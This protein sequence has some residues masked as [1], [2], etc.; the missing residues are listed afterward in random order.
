VSSPRSRRP[1]SL[2][3]TS[4]IHNSVADGLAG[5][6]VGD[7]VS[8]DDA[9]ARVA[10]ILVAAHDPVGGPTLVRFARDGDDMRLALLPVPDDLD[11]LDLLLCSTTPQEWEA[12]GL[13]FSGRLVD[14]PDSPGGTARRHPGRWVGAVLVLRDGRS[15]SVLDDGS[16]ARRISTGVDRSP[17]E[18]RFADAIRRSLGLATA[19]PSFGVGAVVARVWLHRVHAVA[20]DGRPVDADVVA[21]LRPPMPRSWSDLRLQCADGAWS[22]LWCD[23]EVADWMDDGMFSRWCLGAFPDPVEVLVDL[24]ELAAPSAAAPLAEAFATWR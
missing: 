16:G 3:D 23:P 11:P 20:V 22:E 10:E 12:L 24:T 2:V 4:V 1:L 21:A 19:P 18:G 17:I 8:A 5:P 6:P 13:V 7:A 14:L 9:L 15:V